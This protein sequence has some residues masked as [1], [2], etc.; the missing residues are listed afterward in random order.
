MGIPGIS[1]PLQYGPGIP[2]P[3][4][5]TPNYNLSLLFAYCLSPPDPVASKRFIQEG[6]LTEKDVGDIRGLYQGL[7]WPSLVSSFLER[8]K[9]ESSRPPGFPSFLPPSRPPLR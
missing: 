9:R 7:V 1:Q 4:E 5:P 6:L 8:E 2:R 3:L